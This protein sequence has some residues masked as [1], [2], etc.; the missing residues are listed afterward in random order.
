[1]RVVADEAMAE[2]QILA[3]IAQ[4]PNDIA[5]II[6]EPIQGEGG[7]NHFRAEFFRMLRRVC[8]EHEMLLIFDEVQAGMGITG[9]MWCCQHFDVVPDMLCF[10]KKAQVCGVLAGP[11]LDEVAENVFRKPGRINSTW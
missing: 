1:K 11:R 8:N 4:R 3:A 6:V 7:D 2:K 5:A 9:R 10:G